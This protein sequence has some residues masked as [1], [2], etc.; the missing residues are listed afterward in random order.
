MSTSRVYTNFGDL[1][2]AA[3]SEADP[4]RKQQLL[5]DVKR[6]L[7]NWA[8]SAESPTSA[9]RKTAVRLEAQDHLSIRS[10]A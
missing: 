7:D 6:A 3:F 8:A 4:E 1:Y 5:A 9:L 2:R 10:V